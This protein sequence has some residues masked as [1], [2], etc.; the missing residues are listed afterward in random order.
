VVLL[1]PQ[2]VPGGDQ[3]GTLVFEGTAP[4]RDSC[5]MSVSSDGVASGGFPC[6]Q[7]PVRMLSPGGLL[8]SWTTNVDETDLTGMPGASETVAGRLARVFSGSARPSSASIAPFMSI[9]D[10]DE[11]AGPQNGPSCSQIGGDQMAEAAISLGPGSIDQMIACIRAPADRPVLDR[12]AWDAQV[13][14]PDAS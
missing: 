13:A 12:G 8:V 1:V 7:A 6:G 5:P 9:E 11:T 3:P 10:S 4:L 14:A 2:Q